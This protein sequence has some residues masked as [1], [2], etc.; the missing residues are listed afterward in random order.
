MKI[1]PNYPAALN[2]LASISLSE[3][4]VD[5]ALQDLSKQASANPKA[6]GTRLLL[7]RAYM[8]KSDFKMAE[9]TLNNAMDLASTPAAKGAVLESLATIKLG[10]KQFPQAVKLAGD[11][12]DLTPK[13]TI[14]LSVLGTSYVAE[15]QPDQAIEAI[16]AR[17]DKAP[18]WAEGFAILG[19]VAKDLQRLPAAIDALN[20]ALTI[21]SKLTEARLGLGDVYFM[22]K[23]FDLALQQYDLATRQSSN[24]AAGQDSDRSYALLRMGQIYERKSDFASARVSYE[25]ALT[26]NPDNVIAKNNLAWLYAEHGG[27]VDVALKLAEEAKEK[28]PNDPGI[29]DTLGWIY[30][31]KGSYEAAVD[32]LKDSTAK[33]PN[34]ASYL[35]HLGTA[36]YKLGRNGEARKEL[37]AALN[38]PNFGDAADARKL[39]AQIPPK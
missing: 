23:Q 25:N 5:Q 31:K 7:A 36:Y 37:E 3:G 18:D 4:H 21:D 6:L 10:Q 16:K 30:V 13:S 19:R 9:S 27:N 22:N 29:A 33:E 28:A 26:A 20:R 24:H 32:N 14:A 17:L 39:L 35:Y 2:T 1:N 34:N 12:L 38:M 8:A 11:A 15:K